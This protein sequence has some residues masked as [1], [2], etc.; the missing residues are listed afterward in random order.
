ML[1]VTIYHRHPGYHRELIQAPPKGVSYDLHERM[2]FVVPTEAIFQG[3]YKK[4]VQYGWFC[5][6]YAYTPYFPKTVKL[7]HAHLSPVLGKRPYV[8]DTDSFHYPFFLNNLQFEQIK[9]LKVPIEP[10][11]KQ[12]SKG[13]K[14][15]KA[16][17]CQVLKEKNCKK[18]LPWSKWC[19]KSIKD[20]LKDSSIDKKVHQLYPAVDNISCKKT[21]TK[22][23]KLLYVGGHQSSSV[24]RKG[25]DDVLRAFNILSKKN[26]NIGLNYVGSVPR[27]LSTSFL[28]NTR[29]SF[30]AGL[31]KD[32]LF[33]I[34]KDS[35]IFVLPTRADSF[36][37]SLLEAMNFSLPVIT[38]KGKC[39][40]AAEEIV[41]DSVSGF[42]I[43]RNWENN[44]SIEKL[45]LKTF[46]SKIS[47][48]IENENLRR[49]MGQ[50]GKEEIVS[51]KFCVKKRNRK[52][53]QIYE[54][55]L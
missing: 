4:Y 33:K 23:V 31:T 2:K 19:E 26:K 44:H 10:R 5:H 37:M 7:V 8:L 53:K 6:S 21:H 3:E 13:F 1:K 11:Y 41:E 27:N 32:Q 49:N 45:D 15:R 24:Y 12:C 48:L 39:A 29:I 43:H 14:R 50:A 28:K 34:Y 35:D 16:L 42:L 36:G 54:E 46:V 40:P 47:V 17:V 25:G 51:G 9:E 30:Y 20:L 18:I 55:A 22:T 38:I 52:L